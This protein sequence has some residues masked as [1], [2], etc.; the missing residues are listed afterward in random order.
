MRGTE[1]Q[2]ALWRAAKREWAA[3]NRQKLRDVSAA[4]YYANREKRIAVAK[5]HYSKNR[6]KVLDYM[7]RRAYGIS[8]AER[9]AMR[10]AQGNRCAICGDALRAGKNGTNIDHD[11]AMP[12]AASGRVRGLL[13]SPCNLGLGLFKDDPSRLRAAA[14][15]VESHRRRK[16]G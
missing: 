12:T 15:Y 8:A 5:I 6:E 7:V 4:Y 10:T 13:C 9:E 1:A 2:R 3:K 16:A 14:S 11:R